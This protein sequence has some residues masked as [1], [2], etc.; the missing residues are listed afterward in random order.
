MFIHWGFVQRSLGTAAYVMPG[1]FKIGAFWETRNL[2][3]LIVH[4]GLL[5]GRL[6]G[7]VLWWVSL[8]SVPELCREGCHCN[9]QAHSHMPEAPCCSVSL[10][11]GELLCEAL[12]VQSNLHRS[13]FVVCSETRKPPFMHRILPETS[14]VLVHSGLIQRPSWVQRYWS[15]RGRQVKSEPTKKHIMVQDL[16]AE[17]H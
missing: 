9:F 12:R 3:A 4:F 6:L 15:C 5:P 14:G 16:F 13:M 10:A 7:T 17:R 1:V 8:K 11:Y 2:V